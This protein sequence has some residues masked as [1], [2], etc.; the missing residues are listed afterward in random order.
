MAIDPPYRLDPFRNI[1]NVHWPETVTGPGEQIFIFRRWSFYPVDGVL[2]GDWYPVED[3]FWAAAAADDK[4]VPRR[5][6]FN[7]GTTAE[8]S[9]Y[10]LETIATRPNRSDLV[11]AC[12]ML[13]D[14]FSDPPG[15]G[16]PGGIWNPQAAWLAIGG[17]PIM[18]APAN[19]M[20]P[21]PHQ[22]V[23]DG[24]QVTVYYHGVKGS[25]AN[26]DLSAGE[27]QNIINNAGHPV[28]TPV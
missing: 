20:Q 27:L 6:V 22:W 16:D 14:Q 13:S 1:V 8:F 26:N 10:N 3:D 9:L 11:E 4:T 2:Q 17:G 7:E 18:G 24:Q 12:I 23:F 5:T 19:E 28:F 15:P 25:Y 21:A